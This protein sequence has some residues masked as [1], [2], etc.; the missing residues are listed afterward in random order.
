MRLHESGF[1]LEFKSNRIPR[2]TITVL[3]YDTPTCLFLFYFI[4]LCL[5]FLPEQL[6]HVHWYHN[7]KT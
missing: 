4:Y 1:I 3:V 5:S 6:V 7:T 2:L